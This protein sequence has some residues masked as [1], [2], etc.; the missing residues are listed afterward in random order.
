MDDVQ[1]GQQL[2]AVRMEQHLTQEQ[3]AERANM[4]SKRICDYERGVFDP[5]V[6]KIRQLA[7]ALGVPAWRLLADTTDG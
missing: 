6:T 7:D 3:L 4:G 2:K 1:F 5:R